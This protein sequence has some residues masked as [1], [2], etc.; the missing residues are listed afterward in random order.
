MVA[1]ANIE[2]ELFGLRADQAIFGPW[3]KEFMKLGILITK[4]KET[5]LFIYIFVVVHSPP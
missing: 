5:C 1:G 4:F 3:L 2:F